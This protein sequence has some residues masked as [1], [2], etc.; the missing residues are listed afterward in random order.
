MYNYDSNYTSRTNWFNVAGTP[1]LVFE[2]EPL[3]AFKSIKAVL[4]ATFEEEPLEAY[5]WKQS[6]VPS[7]W[8]TYWTDAAQEGG[9]L[10]INDPVFR[11]HWTRYSGA[12][13]WIR[14][15]PKEPSDCEGHNC[16][17]THST[18][19]HA[20][21]AAT[22]AKSLG[23]PL[24]V[25]VPPTPTPSKLDSY[26]CHWWMCLIRCHVRINGIPSS[27]GV[28]RGPRDHHSTS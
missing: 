6:I 4:A 9:G 15:D 27:P 17:G 16:A 23:I 21:A 26:N 24:I 5:F 2:P 25:V 1:C 10:D 20:A 11:P 12:H 22:T 13:S 28:H 19:G 18:V 7:P 14:C 8:D 3:N